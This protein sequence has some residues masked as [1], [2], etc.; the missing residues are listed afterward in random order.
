[1]RNIMAMATMFASVA[2]IAE[3]NEYSEKYTNRKN[4]HFKTTLTKK[5]AD[6][7]KKSK[8]AR[9]NRKR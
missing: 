3:G 4:V 9:K 8:T 6:K 2:G 7:R 5:Q 1:M